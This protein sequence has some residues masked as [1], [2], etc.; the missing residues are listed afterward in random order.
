MNTDKASHTPADAVCETVMTFLLTSNQYR[1]RPIKIP[2]IISVQT[3]RA[4][5]RSW[6]KKGL[7]LGDGCGRGRGLT[8][9]E[10]CFCSKSFAHLKKIRK[11]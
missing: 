11:R 7:G 1:S 5:L 9:G 2:Q 6:I 8:L 3:S 10:V 4:R